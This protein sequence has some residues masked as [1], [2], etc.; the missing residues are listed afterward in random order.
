MGPSTPLLLLLE[1]E[2]G[3]QPAAFHCSWSLRLRGTSRDSMPAGR[4]DSQV[5]VANGK[6]Y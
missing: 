2:A 5:M 6:W 3:G 4:D 1:E